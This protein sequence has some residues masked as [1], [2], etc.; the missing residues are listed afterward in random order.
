MRWTRSAGRSPRGGRIVVHGD[1]DVDGVCATAVM[2]RALRSLGANVGW[3]LPGRIDDGYGLSAETVAR[4][5]A[6][7]CDL[8]LTV[9]CAVT[10]VEEVAAARAGGLEVVVTDH[11]APRADGA[12]PDC[13]IVHPALC[14]Y[15]C[16]DLCGTGVAY[17][18]AL[19]L[20]AGT[21]AEDVELRGAGDRRRRDGAARREPSAGA[22][23]PGRAGEHGQARVAGADGRLPGGP[24]RARHLRPGLPAGAADQ[25]GRAPAPRRRWA[26]AAADRRRAA[27]PGDRGRAGCG[28]HRAARGRAADPV[29]GRER[30]CVDGHA[31]R[32]RAGGR[33]LAPRRDRDRGVA[34][35]RALPPPGDPGRAR[36]RARDGL[37]AQHPR[38]RPAR[39]AAR[40][41]A[42]SSSAT[43]VTGPP[44]A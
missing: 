38:L 4:L 34:D 41:R 37:G 25:R 12:L 29:G 9:D 31:Q 1:Y 22:R 23:R 6:G 28:Q 21:A 18:L 15:P 19:A 2:V 17:K 8:L 7:D 33:G 32:V 42:G 16:A 26:R 5:A 24:E 43:A 3:F 40:I 10:A 13:P 39:R 44:R 35:R 14:G 36:R 20:G 30:G 27:R 11:H